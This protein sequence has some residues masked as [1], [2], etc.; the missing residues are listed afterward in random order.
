MKTLLLMRHA[1][2][3]WKNADLP[4]YERPLKKRGRRDTHAM[5][6]LLKQE[7]HFPEQIICSDAQR[8][9]ETGERLSEGVEVPGGI[10][11]TN[12]L[13]LAEMEDLI[14]AIQGF[15]NAYDSGMLIGHNP[16]LEGLVQVLSDEI[17]ALPTAAVAILELPIKKWK[18][19]N[20][21]MSARLVELWR[22]HREK[23][24]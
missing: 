10:S 9:R 2:S 22:P 15:D 23:K 16:G 17:K 5:Q 18:L 21:D 20:E 1:K 13:Y 24:K 11:Y 6:E 14:K 3:S 12:D 19:L 4:D 7:N 8:A